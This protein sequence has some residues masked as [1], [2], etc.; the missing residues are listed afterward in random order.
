MDHER[1]E[2]DERRERATGLGLAV[3]L[4]ALHLVYYARL[5]GF[6]PVDDAYISFRYAVNWAH[7]FGP[8]F[9]P[10]ERVEGYTNFLWM[11]M[12]A[13]AT[14][15][16]AGP[17]AVALILGSLLAVATVL[18][19]WR[20]AGREPRGVRTV[21]VMLLAGDGSFVLWSAS[22]MET[23]LFTFL[24]LAGA[25]A[26]GRERQQGGLPVSGLLF[27]LA[28]MTRPEGALVFALS[29]VYH[30]VTWPGRR[31]GWSV[32]T[33]LLFLAV[34][35][36]YLAWRYHFYGFWLPNTFYAKVDVE[37]AGEA[38]IARGLA[39]LQTFLG[40]H[41]G[42]LIPALI[43]VP[44]LIGASGRGARSDV[45]RS[46]EQPSTPHAPSPCRPARTGAKGEEDKRRNPGF[47]PS[48]FPR[49]PHPGPRRPVA[50]SPHPCVAGLPTGYCLLLVTTYTAY[51]VFVG[52][53]WSVGRFFVPVLPFAYL[54]A[55]RG[56]WR[57][58]QPARRVAASPGLPRS[59]PRHEE[60]EEVPLSQAPLCPSC[61]G[62]EP[63]VPPSPWRPIA[64][65]PGR[66][67]AVPLLGVALLAANAW[68]SSY[69]GE[70]E[71]YALPFE[72]RLSS[73]ARRAAGEWL[74]Q[75]TPVDAVIAVDAA[76]QIP[77]YSQRQ[78]IDMYGLNEVYL[79]HRRVSLGQGTPGHEKLDLTY[80]LGRRPDY[81][82]IYGAMLDAFPDLYARVDDWTDEPGFARYLSMYRRR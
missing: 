22:G 53:D 36:S 27:A 37:S 20:A 21:A 41:S 38:Q 5:L 2:S 60:H 67:V 17:P 77:Y 9:N 16:G 54:L 29:L 59:P 61:L 76:G 58:H 82:V 78:T 14:W 72:V 70:R 64:P 49:F 15:L 7:G 19:L 46:E 32:T 34:F 4:L 35:G 71:R 11:A 23:G 57:L 40:V 50:P 56:G 13:I 69:Y 44:F 47:L 79:A 30:A 3:A 66:R 8:V 73:Q 80:V 52:G 31:V 28:A 10:G 39:H 43:A 51:I 26:F 6:D 12:L 55:A 75:N 62:G 48:P 33:I 81:V 45:A 68:G 25:V 1:H 65:S 63:P 42:P 74:R 24:V 18:V